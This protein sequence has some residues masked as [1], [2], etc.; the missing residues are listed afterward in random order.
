MNQTDPVG[1]VGI[2]VYRKAG[3]PTKFEAFFKS[4]TVHKD[5]ELRGK[6]DNIIWKV[7]K[8]DDTYKAHIDEAFPVYAMFNG[9]KK[10]QFHFQ[11]I[12]IVVDG[13]HGM[14]SRSRTHITQV[15]NPA[16]GNV[17]ITLY[18]SMPD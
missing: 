15:G 4:E 14:I 11:C 3:L 17:P 2:S 7:T 12:A 1:S 16:I 13:S 8:K 18:S 9:G 10:C 5:V 6:V